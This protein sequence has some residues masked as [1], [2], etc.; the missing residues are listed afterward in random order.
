[1]I[2]WKDSYSVGNAEIDSQHRKL[3]SLCNQCQDLLAAEVSDEN[4]EQL[5]NLLHELG[6]YVRSH[7]D[8]EE[9]LLRRHG[10]PDLPTHIGEHERYWEQFADVLVQAVSGEDVRRNVSKLLM[11]WWFHHIQEVDMQYRA[12]VSGEH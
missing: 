11:S 7:F 12:F 10:Y 4:Y 5:H 8:F 6:E 9:A 3:L 2:E 1:M